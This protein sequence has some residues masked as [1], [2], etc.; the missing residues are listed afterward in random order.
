MRSSSRCGMRGEA[1]AEAELVEQGEGGGVHGV[2]AE[3]AQEVGVLL[4]HRDLDAGAGHEQPR[5]IPAG[6][7]PTTRQVV[8]SLFVMR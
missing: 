6:P 1:L 2:A 7:P 5:T 8:R 3:V 4:Q